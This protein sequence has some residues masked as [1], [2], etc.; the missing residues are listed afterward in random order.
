MK[1]GRVRLLLVLMCVSAVLWIAFAKLVVPPLIE[2]AYRGESL[3][4]L[5][6]MIKG[7]RDN[8]LSHYLQKW[9]WLIIKYLL[10]G[11]AVGLLILVVSSPTFFRR[12]VGEATPGSLGAIRMLTC[13]ILLL[14]L[15]WEDL[16]S[17]ALVPVELREPDTEPRYGFMHYLYFLPVGF[18]GFVTNG[19][20]LRAFKWLTELILF[21]GVIGWATR[22]VIPLAALCA[23]L[24]NGI[25]VE[26]SFFWHQNLVPIYLLAVLSFTPCGDGWSVDRLRKVYQGRAVAAADQGSPT[27]GW[28]R[29]VCWVAIALPYVFNGLGKLDG[30]EGLFW[31]NATNMRSMLYQD[32]LTPREFNWA[33]SLYL[34]PAPDILFAMLGLFALLTETSF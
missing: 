34:A 9:D 8:P 19:T 22:V 11:F 5:N 27:Y 17:I 28:S 18:E 10:N 15:S 23:L 12:F 7:Q 21:L 33:L 6:S 31:W 32:S 4:L 2:R 1:L 20:S 16:A 30:G 14:T 13:A 29:Y 3:P 26:Y 25:L 24:L